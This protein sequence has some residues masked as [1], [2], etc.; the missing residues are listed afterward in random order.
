MK[1]DQT[2]ENLGYQTYKNFIE[3]FLGRIKGLFP[4]EILSVIIF[5][6]VSR[7]GAKPDS[8]IDM[9]IFFNDELIERKEISIALTKLLISL[10]NHEQYLKLSAQGIFPEIYPFLISKNKSKDVLWVTLDSM[11]NGIIIFDKDSF[12]ANLLKVQRENI[13]KQGGGKIVLNP[14]SWYWKLISTNAEIL[15]KLNLNK[16][17]HG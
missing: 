1:Q 10:R 6:S 3:V 7:N 17:N 4:E 5:G 12:G 2:C 11:E 9:F 8:D 13:K 15:K 16:T 14:T